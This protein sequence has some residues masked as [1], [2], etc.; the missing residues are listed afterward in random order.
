MKNLIWSWILAFSLAYVVGANAQSKEE[1][2][3]VEKLMSEVKF[4]KITA[5]RILS[6]FKKGGFENIHPRMLASEKDIE[7]L[8]ELAQSKDP[9]VEYSW[10]SIKGGAEW[11]MRQPIPAG[12]LDTADVRRIGTHVTSG[13]MTTLLMTYWVTGEEKYA[14]YAFKLYENLCTYEDWGIAIK[15]PY[16]DRHYLDTAMGLFCAALVYDGLYDF[17]SEE[18]KDFIFK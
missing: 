12:I 3:Q 11:V 14:Q 13:Y 2:A 10:E 7:R 17:L 4:E 18:Q 15:P 9:L 6:D 5:E 1:V 8:K 16:K